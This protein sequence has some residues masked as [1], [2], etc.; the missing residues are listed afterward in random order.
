MR[1]LC[2]VVTAVTIMPLILASTA[3][4][5]DAAAKTAG[6]A[7]GELTL[8]ASKSAAA[9]AE[10]AGAATELPGLGAL[11]S[12]GL[13][14][15]LSLS[16]PS[17]GNCAATGAYATA[18]DGQ[19][20]YVADE[21]YG[22][23]HRAI[24]IPGLAALDGGVSVVSQVGSVSCPSEGNC[25]AVGSYLP[26]T[27]YEVTFIIDEVDNRWR[28][29]IRVPGLAAFNTF[30][31]AVL[32]SVSCASAG[33][34]AAVG[35]AFVPATNNGQGFIVDEVRGTWRHA[36]E[37]PG[38]AS[39]TG[40]AWSRAESVSC[41]P[42]G[43]CTVL[44]QYT[45]SGASMG[46][47][48]GFV[49][50]EVHGAWRPALEI[51]GLAILNT[52][53]TLVD[54]MIVSC[55]SAGNCS[56]GGSYVDNYGYTHGFVADEADGTW[57][58]ATN[59]PGTSYFQ[60]GV[61]SVSCPSVGNCAAAGYGSFQGLV[62]AQV[63]GTWQ[64]ATQVPG[65]ATLGT[66]GSG[67]LSVS[68]RSTGNCSAVGYYATSPTSYQGFVAAQTGGAWHDAT[69]VPGL[70]TLNTGNNAHAALVSCPHVG[71]CVI[72]GTYT[73]NAGHTQVFVTG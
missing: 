42:G 12:G 15:V 56:V 5:A 49:A 68:C 66:S 25:V 30:G 19:Q 8:M 62:A 46:T 59:V 65:L 33:N 14:G 28:P 9:T 67:S 53:G 31:D 71:K 63:G 45:P 26:A 34:C 16:C 48:Q 51:P 70:A 47:T 11:N 32:N 39:L 27:G 44:G 57:Q 61:W 2:G 72:A 50:D 40:G 13:A 52:A 41:S 17:N 24:E 3:S 55:A 37:V 73:D 36:E 69:Q 35:V 60:S 10:V 6:P 7:A 22:S 4:L 58:N 54:L 20:G 23:W 43:N 18:S 21:V 29:A 38:L 64:D 1:P